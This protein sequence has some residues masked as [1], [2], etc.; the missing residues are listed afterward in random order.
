[1]EPFE[2]SFENFATEECLDRDVPE[3]KRWKNKKM[4]Q[5]VLKCSLKFFL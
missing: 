4:V 1:M 3:A 5:R 2:T